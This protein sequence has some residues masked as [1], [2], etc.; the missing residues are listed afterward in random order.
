MENRELEG[1]RIYGYSNK[2]L[3]KPIEEKIYTRDSLE[4]VL[5]RFKNYEITYS[6][7]YAIGYRDWKGEHKGTVNYYDMKLKGCKEYED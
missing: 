5:K 1:F 7:S 2:T 6:N 4:E 3:N